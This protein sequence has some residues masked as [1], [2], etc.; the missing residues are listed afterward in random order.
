M[1]YSMNAV[2]IHKKEKTHLWI[3]SILLQQQIQPHDHI[4]HKSCGVKEKKKTLFH[5]VVKQCSSVWA[6][7]IS[8]SFVSIQESTGPLHPW[9]CWMST[10]ERQTTSVYSQKLS[11]RAAAVVE[12]S[13]TQAEQSSQVS[14]SHC[15][16]QSEQHCWENPYKV[17]FPLIFQASLTGTVLH[18]RRTMLFIY[19]LNCKE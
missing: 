16:P 7:S 5:C 14:L 12:I 4:V 18:K 2:R 19:G 17:N 10:S 3:I 15:D 9:R 6:I 13:H 1:L 8:D 11:H